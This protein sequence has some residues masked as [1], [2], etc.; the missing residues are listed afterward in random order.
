MTDS[1]VPAPESTRRPVWGWS[2]VLA[3]A[4]AL[5]VLWA[6]LVPVVPLSD[7]LAYDLYAR[8]LAKFDQYCLSPGDPSAYWPVGTSFIYS[9]LYRLFGTGNGSIVGFNIILGTLTT[10]LVLELATRWFGPKAGLLAGLLYAIWPSQIEFTTILASEL[11]FN[12]FILLAIFFW[13]RKAMPN[14]TD[15]IL[16]GIALAAASYV[17]PL[18]LILPALF[19]LWTLARGKWT[20]MI[21]RA[22]ITTA[23]MLLLILPWTIRNYFAFHTIVLVSTNG[24]ANL[25]MG[26]NPDSNG[27]YMELPPRPPGM[28]EAQFDN[29]L[30]KIAKTYIRQ[31]PDVFLK[32]SAHRIVNT[33]DRETIGVDWNQEALNDHAIRYLK[34]LS[35]VYWW[36]MLLGGIVGVG[37]LVTQNPILK[38]LLHPAI[39]MWIYFAT[40]HAVTVSNDRYHFPTIPF[41]AGLAAM[42]I[43]TRF[44]S[45]KTRR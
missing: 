26:N 43:V 4:L 20:A 8:N 2:L 25:W 14:W 30:G 22:A 24:G 37:I 42:T 27:H 17:R 44:S 19:L 34:I 21:A 41:I 39:V 3:L 13:N 45:A 32:R 5:R 35:T 6:A 10:L 31:H 7:S 23:V 36:A 38:T 15:A 11:L 1:A 28:N 33:F 12:F 29:H 9:V 16:A 40:V 18:A